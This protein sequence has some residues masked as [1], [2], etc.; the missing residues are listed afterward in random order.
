MR[1][2]TGR[3]GRW[4]GRPMADWWS[5]TPRRLP[6]KGASFGIALATLTHEGAL[7]ALGLAASP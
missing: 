7:P 6:G 3:L 1:R 4:L 2:S 5:I